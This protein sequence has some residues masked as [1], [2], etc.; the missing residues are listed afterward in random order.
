MDY[1]AS[2]R[3]SD[4]CIVARLPPHWPELER[5]IS[6]LSRTLLL[7]SVE[8]HELVEV[9]GLSA[10]AAATGPAAQDGLQQQHRLWQ[11]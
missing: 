10:G 5:F 3:V 6:P 9:D 4:L 8:E 11:R 2:G 7:T 1:A